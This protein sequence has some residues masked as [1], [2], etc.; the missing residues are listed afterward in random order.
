ML[1]LAITA[2]AAAVAVASPAPAASP[3]PRPA[4]ASPAPTSRPRPSAVLE[5]TVRG[6]DGRPIAQALVLARDEQPA[7]VGQPW[8]AHTDGAGQFRITVP[9]SLSYL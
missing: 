3:S 7:S 1:L 2:S 9:P 8:I 6:P 5:G 4:V